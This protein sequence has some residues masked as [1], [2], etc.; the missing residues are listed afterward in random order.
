MKTFDDLQK[1]RGIIK[2][3]FSKFT[4]GEINDFDFIVDFLSRGV[5]KVTFLLGVPSYI[6]KKYDMKSDEIIEKHLRNMRFVLST[7]GYGNILKKPIDF[8][9]L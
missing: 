2:D 8:Q 9:V 3:L 4:N 6:K 7:L 5:P 1:D